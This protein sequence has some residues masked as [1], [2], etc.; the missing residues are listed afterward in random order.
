MKRAALGG[1]HMAES[2]GS[3]DSRTV[4]AGMRIETAPAAAMPEGCL[5]VPIIDRTGK[6]VMVVR[7]DKMPD[8]LRHEFN[9]H[10]ENINHSRLLD[11]RID[12]KPPPGHPH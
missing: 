7:E 11:P 2:E 9:T 1:F 6:L 5:V 3:T 10:F 8:D 4:A 12:E